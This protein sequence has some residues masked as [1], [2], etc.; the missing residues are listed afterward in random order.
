MKS[1]NRTKEQRDKKT[2]I[3]KYREQVVEEVREEMSAVQKGD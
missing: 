1:R 2:Q 3:A